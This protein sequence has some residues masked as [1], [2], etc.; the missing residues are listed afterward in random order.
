MVA[1][2]EG[3]VAINNTIQQNVIFTMREVRFFLK[4]FMADI[5]KVKYTMSALAIIYLL[6]AFCY[7]VEVG[8]LYVLKYG[9]VLN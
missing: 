1:A 2:E 5:Y 6:L 9:K 8:I 7:F 4:S 3:F